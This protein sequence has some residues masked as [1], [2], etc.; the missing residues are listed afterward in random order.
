M[1][2]P[3]QPADPF[4][5]FDLDGTLVDSSPGIIA[6]FQHALTALGRPAPPDRELGWVVGP[7]LRQ[8]F[9][10][11]VGDA[12]PVEAT[13]AHYRERYSAGGLFQAVVYEGV[14]AALSD[15]GAEGY[16]LFLCTSK[17]WPFARQVIAHFGL[18]GVFDYVYGTELDG[19][20]DDKGDLIA[21]LLSR[22]GLLAARGCMVGDR[23]NDASAAARNGMSCVGVLWGYGDRRELAENGATVLCERPQDLKGCIEGLLRA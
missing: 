8:S 5:L 19:T 12:A 13:V 16:R 20:F 10:K 14:A 3:R 7:P 15:L 1:S 9:A 6:S 21:H 23:D 11:L 17:P 18:D 22:E 2:D 4:V